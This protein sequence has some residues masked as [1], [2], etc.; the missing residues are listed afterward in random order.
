[1]RFWK[2]ARVEARAQE[3]AG[4]INGLVTRQ[5]GAAH[6]DHHG[7]HHE[8][9]YGDRGRDKEG[10]VKPGRH[11]VPVCR[12]PR[13][14]SQHIWHL[15]RARAGAAETTV[16][17]TVPSTA[18]PIT[19][20]TCRPAFSMLAAAPESASGTRTRPVSVT[21][22]TSRPNPIPTSRPPAISPITVPAT[23]RTA[24]SLRLPGRP[25]LAALRGIER[26]NLSDARCRIG[27]HAFV[28]GVSGR[29]RGAPRITGDDTICSTWFP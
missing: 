26:R 25:R 16:Q 8:D 18:K 13:R 17:A 6:T 12:R 4:P 7:G 29:P 10:A 28:A 2:R 9:E 21:G 11:R 24:R 23:R 5:I 19:P 3:G 20:P 14:R 27:A 1:M 15:D 22:T